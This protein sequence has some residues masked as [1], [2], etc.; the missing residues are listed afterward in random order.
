MIPWTSTT[1]PVSACRHFFL[2]FFLF[3][4]KNTLIM[5]IVRFAGVK[6]HRR[7][8]ESRALFLNF[9]CVSIC[10]RNVLHV[11]QMKV[12]FALDS[13]TCWK[14]VGVVRAIENKGWEIDSNPNQ[15]QMWNVLFE[16]GLIGRVILVRWWGEKRNKEIVY[17]TF[18]SRLWLWYY[19][20]SFLFSKV[21]LCISDYQAFPNF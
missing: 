5:D 20:Y 2:L 13:A 10:L 17:V 3:Q 1:S 9:T 12:Q 21:I 8:S 19:F 18:L 7:F 4:I 16:L 14:C 15:V 11:W 6:I